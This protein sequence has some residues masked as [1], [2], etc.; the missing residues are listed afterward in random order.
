MTKISEGPQDTFLMMANDTTHAHCLLQ[1][2]DYEP[3]LVVDNSEYDVD[4][5]KQPQ[6]MYEG[7]RLKLRSYTQVSHYH[8]NMATLLQLGEWFDYLREMGVYDNTRIIL[9]SDH[10]YNL[11]G[12]NLLCH[13]FRM[14]GDRAASFDEDVELYMPLLMVKDFNATGFTISKDFMTNA[15]TPTLAT[16]GLI[17]DPTN[18]FTGKPI[19]SDAKDG[20]QKVLATDHWSIYVNNEEKFMEDSWFTVEDDPYKIKNWKYVGEG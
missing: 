18:P 6:Y 14:D 20:P 13:A 1:K 10:G 17:E 9:V 16:S 19:N 7:R 2:P 8:V 5:K 3:A 4:L 15:D 11:D 12:F